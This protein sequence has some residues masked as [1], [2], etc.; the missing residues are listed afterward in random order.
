MCRAKRIAIILA[1]VSFQPAVMAV[2]STASRPSGKS[3]DKEITPR[4]LQARDG[5]LLKEGRPYRG[6]GVN[7][8]SAFH[9][10]LLDPSNKSYRAG[11]RTL[12]HDY[13]IPFIR[14]AACG[15]WPNEWRL[16][17]EDRPRYFQLLDAVVEEA[18][19]NNLGL[20]PSLFWHAPTIP[21]LVGEHMDSWGNPQ[22]K[23]HRLMKDY[24]REVVGRYR[25]S[26]AVWAWEFGNEFNLMI[27]LPDENQW[28]PPVEVHMGTPP[29]RNGRD[30]MQRSF[31]DAALA[32]FA[33]AVRALDQDRM[34]I[35][36]NAIS[37][38]CAY[39]LHTRQRWEKDT[40]SQWVEMLI[41]DNPRPFESL[42]IHVYPHDEG[43]YFPEGVSLDDLIRLC[44]E[45]AEQSKRVLFVGEFGASR[46]LGDR[47]AQEAFGKLTRTIVE[48]QVPLSAVWVFDLPQQD[49]TYNIIAES[50]RSYM[51]KAISEANRRLMHGHET[52]KSSRPSDSVDHR[53][54]TRPREQ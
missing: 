48:T 14:F 41:L 1:V 7:Y 13:G 39:H 51:L 47:A 42:S 6:M 22:S 3:S 31:M 45:F 32:G 30:K 20:I 46:E 9:R 44:A 40:R 11:F 2:D 28:V 5:V 35:T 27:D 24:V 50:D 49:G 54:N 8:F 23:T 38:S 15:Y 25:H 26:P 34:L 37:R 29:H 33:A 16:Y 10:T 17:F 36:G 43:E 52:P 4:G 53:P 12:R 21:D 19:R 18:E